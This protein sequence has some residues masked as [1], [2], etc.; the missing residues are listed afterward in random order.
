M[1]DFIRQETDS[2]VR[3]VKKGFRVA[4][5]DQ[6]EDPRKAKGIVKREVVRVVSPGTLT[7][8]N[9]LDAHLKPADRA[10]LLAAAIAA[11]KADPQVAAVFTASQIARVP[12][13][14]GNPVAWSL[15][16]R[17][18]ASF[19]PGRSGDFVVFLKRDITPIANT[20]FY[21]A[22]HGSP[23]DYDRRVPILFWRRGSPASTVERPVETTDI[24]PTV[25]S[26]IGLA[27]AP[28]S[29]DGRCLGDPAGSACNR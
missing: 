21:V 22:T 16:Q 10:R 19:Y 1:V 6:V 14:T 11:Y 27:V 13:P 3:L 18:R 23:Y 17:A 25:A 8:A 28:G 26:M 20:S 9:Y 29:I 7:D 15:I 24:M 4:I 12:V 5:C 2:I